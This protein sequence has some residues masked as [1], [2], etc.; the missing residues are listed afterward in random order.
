MTVCLCGRG[1]DLDKVNKYLSFSPFDIIL[2]SEYVDDMKLPDCECYYIAKSEIKNTKSIILQISRKRH[3]QYTSVVLCKDILLD[4]KLSK[5]IFKC[6]VKNITFVLNINRMFDLHY[7]D[8]CR[9]NI[10]TETHQIIEV[11][12]GRKLPQYHWL[13]AVLPSVLYLDDDVLSA[14]LSCDKSCAKIKTSNYEFEIHICDD[15]SLAGSN[16]AKP[17]IG[18][19]TAYHLAKIFQVENF[20][21]SIV[22]FGSRKRTSVSGSVDFGETINSI[23]FKLVDDSCFNKTIS[24]LTFNESIHKYIDEHYVV[25]IPTSKRLVFCKSKVEADH[26]LMRDS[27]N[28]EVEVI[29]S[30]LNGKP[31]DEIIPE[32]YVI[33]HENGTVSKSFPKYTDKDY[34]IT[35]SDV[36]DLNQRL[37]N[38]K[39]FS[40]PWGRCLKYSIAEAISFFCDKKIEDAFDIIHKYSEHT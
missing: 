17:N 24:Y 21:I 34:E 30:C 39:D 16:I 9:K 15:S 31:F 33:C 5:I 1:A 22:K 20:N 4:S 26:I 40:E 32:H 29:Y 35:S 2:I 12:S 3:L 18:T 37:L 8:D 38:S 13:F 27:N 36:T 6:S 14:Q 23:P 25:S 28:I 10:S 11:F 7:L 19:L